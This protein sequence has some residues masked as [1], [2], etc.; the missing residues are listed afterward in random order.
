[1]A[2]EQACEEYRALHHG[3]DPGY[4]KDF[5]FATRNSKIRKEKSTYMG[6]KMHNKDLSLVQTSAI[7]EINDWDNSHRA[8]DKYTIKDKEKHFALKA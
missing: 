8:G 1:M 7:E 2:H 3:K 4:F 5:V 6:R